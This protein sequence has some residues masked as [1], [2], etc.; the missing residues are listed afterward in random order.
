[1]KPFVEK[2]RP[3]VLDDVVGN[4]IAVRQLKAISEQGNLPNCIIVGPPGTGKTTSVMCLARSMLG[5]TAKTATL[6]LNASDD[7]GIDV[8]REKIKSFAN[9]K[10]TVPEGMHKIIILDEADAMTTAAQQALRMIMTEFS[11]TTRFA[12]ACNDSSK[13]IEPIQSRC[14]IIRYTKLSNEQVCHRLKEVMEME[15]IEYDQ[16]GLEALIFTAEGDMRY[17]LNNLQATVSGFDRVTKDNVFKVCDQPHP[18][19]MDNIIDACLRG[20]FEEACEKVDTVL[21][22]GVMDVLQ[23]LNKVVQVKDFPNEDRRISYLR[24]LT[25]FKMKVLEGMDSHL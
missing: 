15:K 14:A 4:E 24:V 16:D 19:L 17:A 12:L 22:K 7:R 5:D 1:M 18:D 13:I 2:Y 23:T 25:E 10:V 6:E 9:R 21:E 3:L 20:E 11:S 8:V